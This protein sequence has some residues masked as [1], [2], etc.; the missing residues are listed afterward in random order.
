MITHCY[1]IE[2]ALHVPSTPNEYIHP[3]NEI[4]AIMALDEA[5]YSTKG[6]SNS[7]FKKLFKQDNYCKIRIIVDGDLNFLYFVTQLKLKIKF[8]NP[9][10]IY[11]FGNN[12][13]K[14]PQTF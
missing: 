11:Y 9:L 4:T 2:K 10:S 14:S 13:I 7:I 1:Q 5:N 3:C 12:K 8:L 6:N